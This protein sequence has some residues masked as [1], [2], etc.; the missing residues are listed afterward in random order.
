MNI[1]EEISSIC[2]KNKITKFAMKKVTRKYAFEVPN[3]PNEA[4]YMKL[5]YDYQSAGSFNHGPG[6]TF[7]HV[8]GT[9]TGAL[10]TFLLKRKIMGPC[11]LEIKNA[12]FVKRN[13]FFYLIFLDVLVQNGI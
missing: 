10:E 6:K 9:N 8:F 12:N 7:S 5:V 4:E 11:W 3:I 2:K 13:V 1:H